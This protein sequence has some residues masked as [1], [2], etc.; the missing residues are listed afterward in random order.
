[1]KL[2]RWILLLLGVA[3]LAAWGWHWVAED[4][5]HVL[6]RLR[7]WRVETSLL[8]A[9]LLLLLLWA[10][11][12]LAARLLRWPFGA[13]SRRRRR[14]GHKRMAAGLIGLFEGRHELAERSL[15]KAARYTPLRAPAQ[16][17]QADAA[18]RRGAW[19]RA[20]ERLD[21]ATDLAPQ[22]AR[23]LRARVLRERGDP[24]QAAQLLGPEA[25]AGKLT[26][27]G[28]HE[29][30]LALLAS[31]QAARALESLPSLRKSGAL[32]SDA[33][34]RLEKTVLT[35]AL[36]SAGDAQSLAGIWRNLPR[37]RRSD[38]DLLSV[39]AWH[40]AR[41]GAGLAAMGELE[42]SLRKQ[43]NPDLASLYI[44]LEDVPADQRLRQAES[45][46]KNHADD[47]ALLAA[48]GGLCARQGLYGK[49]RDYLEQALQR[50]PSLAP[51]WSALGDVA[52]GDDDQ[53]TAA[54]CY[55][56][57][58]DIA[59]GGAPVRLLPGMHGALA[60]VLEERDEHGVP[61]LPSGGYDVEDEGA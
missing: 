21:Q 58:L 55:R 10:L 26:P 3:V 40:A 38:P 4:P 17:L 9:I 31:G 56:N 25:E 47:A 6:I 46:L 42:S 16:L 15:V 12:G 1:M 5:G 37:G 52:Q 19:D 33:M 53:A 50:D 45:W 14:L 35:E 13:V 11:I 8:V 61:R 29:L 43:W 28:W 48:L 18:L 32:G 24:E 2:W 60:P 27:A 39:Y 57:A 7:G 59:S 20:L 44:G 22:A 36:A 34:A 51:A 23:V 41:S 49:A 30:V 54:Q